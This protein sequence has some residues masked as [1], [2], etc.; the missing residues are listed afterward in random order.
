MMEQ[1]K[2]INVV[3]AVI[4]DEGEVLCMQ[5]GK[6]KFN[7][8]SYKWEFPGGKVEQGETPEEALRREIREEMSMD[9]S[10]GKHLIT[11]EHEYPDF[12]ITMAAY[13]CSPNCGRAFTMNE[14]QAF[15]WLAPSQLQ[16]LDWAAAD[17]GIMNVVKG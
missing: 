12:C 13:L 8:T 6:T 16:T 5:R 3:A 4:M 11:V 2:H 9:I 10:V 7:Y 17:V 15:Q 1:K 14:H